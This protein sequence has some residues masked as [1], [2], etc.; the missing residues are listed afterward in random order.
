MSVVLPEIRPDGDII[1]RQIVS[2]TDELAMEIPFHQPLDVIRFTIK[3][4]KAS[5][6]SSTLTHTDGSEAIKFTD[7]ALTVDEEEHFSSDV[8]PVAI[9]EKLEVISQNAV[10][11][12]KEVIILCR[13]RS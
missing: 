1:Y 4:P 5:E 2:G 8:L 7:N 10:S 6:V 3:A 13:P 12:A 11:G 9:G